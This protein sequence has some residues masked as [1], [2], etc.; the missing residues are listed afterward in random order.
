V[1]FDVIAYVAGDLFT[2]CRLEIQ[3]GGTDTYHQEAPKTRQEGLTRNRT[4]SAALSLIRKLMRVNEC[5]FDVK[6]TGPM[7]R[8]GR[9]CIAYPMIAR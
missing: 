1:S 6:C 4:I 5:A 2:N 8:R 3:S 7:I 9:S